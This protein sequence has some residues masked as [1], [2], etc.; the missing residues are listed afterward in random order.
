MKWESRA[1]KGG[2]EL[3]G[4]H[5]QGGVDRAAALCDER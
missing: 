4:A 2:G 3:G 5:I 1:R